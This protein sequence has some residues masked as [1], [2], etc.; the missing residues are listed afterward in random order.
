MGLL[1]PELT[2]AVPSGRPQIDGVL[3]RHAM[4]PPPQQVAQVRSHASEMVWPVHDVV[5]QRRAQERPSS[6]KPIKHSSTVAPS[7]L[8]NVNPNAAFW[9]SEK[10][11]LGLSRDW[12][13]DVEELLK[14]SAPPDPVEVRN[15]VAKWA[16]AKARAG[17][18]DYQ[19]MDPNDRVGGKF[20]GNWLHGRGA[21]KCNIFVGDAYSSAAVSLLNPKNGNFYFTAEDW[22]DPKSVIPGFRPLKAGEN[23]VRGDI[24]TNGTHVGIYMP[25]HGRKL[26]VSAAALS[27]G[28]K[29][30]HNDWGFRG[31]EGPITY[32]RYVGEPAQRGRRP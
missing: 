21:Y 11:E 32:W 31:D 26:T 23:P 17:N 3:G 8:P 18:T 14:P 20:R 16:E 22:G 2:R 28:N 1:D 6:P 19:L 25:V 30:V 27:K 10:G 5:G 12:R 9:A 24:I 15:K 7:V 29:V 4:T 13:R